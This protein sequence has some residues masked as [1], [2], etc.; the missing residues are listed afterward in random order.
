MK[1]RVLGSSSSGNCYILDGDNKALI[2]EAGMKLQEVKKAM[3]FNLKKVAGCIVTHQHNDHSKYIGQFMSSG[4][5]V[6][7]LKEVFE[8]HKIPANASFA[9]VI[10]PG[11]GYRISDFTVVGFSTAHDSPCLGFIID[12]SES[13]KIFFLTDTMTCQYA[14]SG[15]S[16]I[17]IEANYEDGTLDKNIMAGM[18]PLSLRSRLL[19]SHMEFETTKQ[20]LRNQDMSTVRNIVLIHLSDGNSNEDRFIHEVKAMTGKAV[21]AAKKGLEVNFDRNPF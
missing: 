9:K 1:L 16:H 20:I 4:I 8:A 21:Y 13:G 10:H 17:M 3:D 19:G 7:A 14:F 12:H 5:T 11:C 6:L 2:I 18:F 15:L